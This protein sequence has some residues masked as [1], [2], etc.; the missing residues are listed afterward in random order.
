MIAQAARI[1]IGTLYASTNLSCAAAAGDL[2]RPLGRG[3]ARRPQRR[4]IAT[5]AARCS[6]AYMG[7]G[8]GRPG[9]RRPARRDQG[10][11][12]PRRRTAPIPA[13]G[14]LDSESLAADEAITGNLRRL[15]LRSAGIVSRW[16]SCSTLLVR[17]SPDSATCRSPPSTRT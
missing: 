15:N 6:P 13:V 16:S 14:E 10:Q 9:R 7:G 8:G 2:R 12:D 4:P 3:Y 11:H 1:D 5:G 17:T